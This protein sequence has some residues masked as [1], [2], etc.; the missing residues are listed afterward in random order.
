MRFM[1]RRSDRP[2]PARRGLGTSLEALEGRQLLSSFTATPHPFSVYLPTDLSVRNPI[3]NQPLPLTFQRLVHDENPQSPLLNN[4]GKVV[5]GK[6]RAGNEWTI[7]VHGP[8]SVIVTD[9]TPNDGSLDDNIDTIQLIGT[10]LTKTYVTGTVVGSPFTPTD[11]TVLFNKLIDVKGVKSV[12][13]NGFTLTETVAPANGPKYSNT[14]IMLFGGVQT[15]QFHNIL[16]STSTATNDQPIN[17]LIGDPNT[18]ITV[19]PS[20]KIDNIFNTALPG[21]A[22]TATATLGVGANNTIEV[23]SVT[24]TSGGSGYSSIPTVTFVGGGAV[25]PATATAVV[26][27]GVVTEITLVNGGGGYT[28]VPE[29]VID[30]PTASLTPSTNPG[31]NLIINGEL[32]ALNLVSSTQQTVN[33]GVQFQFPI[34]STTG[35][36]AVRATA[37]DGLRVRGSAV[38][39][40]ASRGAVPFQNGL[41]GL[42]HLGAAG[43][44]NNADAVGL[45]VNGPVGRLRFSRGLGNP[46]GTTPS[47]T[48]LGTPADRLGFPAAGLVGGL[49]TAKK[50]GK[51][52]AGPANSILQTAQNRDFVQTRITGNTNYY[53]Q[54]GNALSSAAIVSAGSIG[55]TNI[56]GNL[57]SSEIKSGFHYPSFAAGLE[58]TRAKSKIAPVEAHGDLVNGVVSATHRPNNGM[59]GSG[60]DQKG[61]GAITGNLGAKNAIYFTGAKTPL[62][63][64]G[65][66]FFAKKK[67]GYLPPPSA[68]TRVHSVQVR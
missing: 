1:R 39:F 36:T 12:I 51:I 9:S 8:G 16:A 22:A 46:T 58:G 42:K 15:L 57:S 32:H 54:P 60:S 2:D 53:P 56:H 37:I 63:N 45:D 47:D 34:V 65:T 31:V 62:L 59:Y 50:I 33:A 4:Q 10:S 24:L 41:S 11:S 20:I 23:A 40:T 5:T 49:V 43:F 19:Q 48:K 38:N 28:S 17:I 68:P 18:P 44:D 27:N 25:T 21:T 14:G 52:T 66:G 55:H 67:K 7:T 3:T 29:V 6:D 35:R 64:T 13:L 26:S 61:N 30:P